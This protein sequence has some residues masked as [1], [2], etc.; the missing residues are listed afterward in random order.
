M[1]KRAPFTTRQTSRTM[2]DDTPAELTAGIPAWVK[3]ADDLR[4]ELARR[5]SP[6]LAAS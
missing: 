6:A 3:A 5:V 1:P 4:A 2:N